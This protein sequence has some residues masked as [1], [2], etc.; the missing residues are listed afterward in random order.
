MAEL[1]NRVSLEQQFARDLSRLTEKQR[2]ELLRLMGSPPDPRN[3]PQAFWDKVE[4]EQREKLIELLV[5]V[6]LLSAGQHGMEQ[7]AAATASREWADDRATDI[8]RRMAEHSQEILDRA[9][10]DWEQ[11]RREAAERVEREMRQRNQEIE[12]ARR[13]FEEEVGGIGDR[14]QPT[15][16]EG[17]RPEP[18]PEPPA[19]HT[20]EEIEDA[21]EEAANN[22]VTEEE[23]EDLAN[24]VFGPN[25]AS[26][27]AV[28]ETTTAASAGGEAAI[29]S[30]VGTSAKDVWRTERDAKVC[31]ICYPLHGTYRED[32]EKEFPTGPPSHVNCRCWIEYERMRGPG[33]AN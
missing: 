3:V 16:P 19:P 23:A 18:P 8:A 1:Q 11:R 4:Q 6:F 14:P 5:M 15:E 12:D 20:D 32:W 17:R 13:E 26:D 33:E 31:A 30:T 21:A 9:A 29:E 27:V 2:Q 28:T 10:I 25:R 7:G 24:V 22:A